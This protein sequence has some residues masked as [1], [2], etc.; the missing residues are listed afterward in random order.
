VNSKVSLVRC[1]SYEREEVFNRVRKSIDLLGGMSSF[2]KSGNQVFI[3]PNL[4]AAKPP[5][6]GIDTH[7]EVVRA[8]IRLVKEQ[9]GIP[10]V[11]D[12][13]GGS[14]KKMDD[15]YEKSGIKKVCEEE[16][17]QLIKFDK[18]E[19]FG[20]IPIASCA[21][22]ADCFI[23]LPKFKTHELTVLTA[24]VKNVFGLVPGLF[25]TEC[26]KFAPNVIKFSSLLVDIFSFA[27]PHLSVVDG[28][29]GMEGEGPGAAGTLRKIGLIAASADAVSIDAVLAVIMGIKPFDVPTTS[30]AHRRG[31]GKG[32]LTQIDIV[33]EDINRLKQVG[34]KLPKTTI[35][36]RMPN[37]PLRAL[38]SL[39]KLKPAVDKGR[40]TGCGLCAESC[41]VDALRMEKGRPVFNYSKC[42]RCLCCHEF[43]PENAIYIKENFLARRIRT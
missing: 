1:A 41:P 14:V 4:L 42:I 23:S 29:V 20:G 10:S 7:P 19:M 39:I 31:L 25:K 22:E 17:A 33:G 27:R 40:C 26:H 13:P 43:C 11:G 6:S 34:F 9:G 15:V 24:A 35:L 12:S 18:I 28:I 32:N 16:K 5:E 38:A 36:H 21:R 3:K 8:V 30:I 2:V 37:L